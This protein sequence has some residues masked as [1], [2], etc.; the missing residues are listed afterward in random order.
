MT[1][2]F[3]PDMKVIVW[4]ISEKRAKVSQPNIESWRKQTWKD[5]QKCR[6]QRRERD[7]DDILSFRWKFDFIC[8]VKLFFQP[9]SPLCLRSKFWKRISHKFGGKSQLAIGIA[10]KCEGESNFS[11]SIK[12]GARTH[13]YLVATVTKLH[14][15]RYTADD[16]CSRLQNYGLHCFWLNQESRSVAW[17]LRRWSSGAANQM[18]PS[19]PVSS[20]LYV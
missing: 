3:Y 10:A 20:T 2:I 16:S 15:G 12:P 11:A 5:L 14:T 13:Q 9:P 4:A 7:R 6:W 1:M 18:Q 17:M 8:N 19:M